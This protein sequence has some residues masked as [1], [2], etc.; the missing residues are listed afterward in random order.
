MHERHRRLHVDLA[1]AEPLVPL[2]HPACLVLAEAVERFVLVEAERLARADV[3]AL[4]VAPV[5]RRR[6]G[7]AVGLL[8]EKRGAARREETQSPGHLV[9]LDGQRVAAHGHGAAFVL[10]RDMDRAWLRGNGEGW[11]SPA[12]CA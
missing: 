9:K 5:G 2:V 11:R 7:G 4:A 3:R 10:K 1:K 12:L 6:E 8:G